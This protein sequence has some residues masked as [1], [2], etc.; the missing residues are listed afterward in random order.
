MKQ[1]KDKLVAEEPADRKG[2]S[3]LKVLDGE[4]LSK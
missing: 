4:D 3:G 1:T 2:I